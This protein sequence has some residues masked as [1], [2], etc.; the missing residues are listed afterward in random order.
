ML[1]PQPGCMH[2]GLWPSPFVAV[3]PVLMLAPL[4]KAV[5]EWWQRQGHLGVAPDAQAASSGAAGRHL[6]KAGALTLCSCA[7]RQKT[8]W[9]FIHAG[10]AWSSADLATL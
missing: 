8:P 4:L 3:K 6:L 1:C 2:E 10:P 5:C 7:A 9:L